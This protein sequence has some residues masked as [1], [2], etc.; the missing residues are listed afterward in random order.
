MLDRIVY[1]HLN[2]HYLIFSVLYWHQHWQYIWA[3]NDRKNQ[4][5][6]R[7]WKKT[8]DKVSLHKDDREQQQRSLHCCQSMLVPYSNPSTH[9]EVS[10][11][12]RSITLSAQSFVLFIDELFFNNVSYG[13]LIDEFAKTFDIII[14]IETVSDYRYINVRSNCLLQQRPPFPIKFIIK[15]KKKFLNAMNYQSIDWTSEGRDESVHL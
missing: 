2:C 8:V 3:I 12:S 14:T 6:S 5:S 4:Q 15:T 11:G 9:R 1:Y 7:F 13:F 10:G